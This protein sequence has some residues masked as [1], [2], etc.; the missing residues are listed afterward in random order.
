MRNTVVGMFVLAFSQVLHQCAALA[1]SKTCKYDLA[2]L[3]SLKFAVAYPFV[4]VDRAKFLKDLKVS[5]PKSSCVVLQ[6][7]GRSIGPKLEK[8]SCPTD[9]K[10]DCYPVVVNNATYAL[11]RQ[12]E[13]LHEAHKFKKTS[14][15][16][17]DRGHAF[18]FCEDG[19]Y[20]NQ[21]ALPQWPSM[22]DAALEY[23]FLISRSTDE[24]RDAAYVGCKY[25]EDKTKPKNSFVTCQKLYCA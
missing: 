7:T 1:T 17:G 23:G 14:G 6:K 22:A 4:S 11:L 18:M 13:L 2:V 21:D 8:V 19:Q 24:R 5:V 15:N 25:G 3:N 12:S 10:A 20:K 9:P 16:R